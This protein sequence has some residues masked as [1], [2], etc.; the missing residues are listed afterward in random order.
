ML[1]L[2]DNDKDNDDD[3]QNYCH[4]HTSNNSIWVVWLTNLCNKELLINNIDTTP[5]QKTIIRINKMIK[6]EKSR[7]SY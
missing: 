7:Q 1:P 3:G 5:L 4:C 2:K 6:S